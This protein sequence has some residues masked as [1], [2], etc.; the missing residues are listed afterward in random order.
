VRLNRRA[1]YEAFSPLFGEF[2]AKKTS[3]PKASTESGLTGFETTL[4]DY[5][6]RH[7]DRICTFEEL[8]QALW[9]RPMWE[10]SVKS[11]KDQRRRI[12]VAVSR[13]R[14]KLMHAG[15]DIYSSRGQGYQFLLARDR[16]V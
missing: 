6:R 8:S 4:Y 9:D 1:K 15:E 2:I 16:S 5:L 10:M 11:H 3:S 12:Q 14:Q 7:T 13:L